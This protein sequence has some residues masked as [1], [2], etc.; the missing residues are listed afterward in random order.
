MAISIYIPTNRAKDPS[1][2]HSLQ[3]LLFVDF[4]NDGRSDGCD[5]FFNV[6]LVSFS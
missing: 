5:F 3:H 6:E 2:P 4:L 1:S